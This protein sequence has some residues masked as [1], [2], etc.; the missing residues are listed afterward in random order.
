MLSSWF[1]V[2]SAGLRNRSLYN[3]ILDWTTEKSVINYITLIIWTQ[4]NII[5]LYSFC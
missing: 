3:Q 1:N 2:L 4:T 5:F